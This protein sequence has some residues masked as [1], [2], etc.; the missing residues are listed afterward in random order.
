LT[1][2]AALAVYSSFG[3][4]LLAKASVLRGTRP[5]MPGSNFNVFCQSNRCTLAADAEDPDKFSERIISAASRDNQKI[6]FVEFHASSIV[7][8][9]DHF[10]IYIQNK[11]DCDQ[12]RSETPKLGA[13]RRGR[14]PYTTASN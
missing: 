11:A 1:L 8:N 3:L 10:A 4:F 13:A 12:M 6:Q 9:R 7:F 5:T 2:H 14:R